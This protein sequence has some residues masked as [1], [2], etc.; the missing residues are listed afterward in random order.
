M[1]EH[2]DTYTKVETIVSQAEDMSCQAKAL[3]MALRS[4]YFVKDGT[5]RPSYEQLMKRSG[6]GSRQT[7]TKHLKILKMR[8]FIDIERISHQ[9]NSYSFPYLHGSKSCTSSKITST[10]T[11]TRLVPKVVLRASTETGTVPRSLPKSSPRAGKETSDFQSFQGTGTET[12]QGPPE[13]IETIM[14]PQASRYKV[15]PAKPILRSRNEYCDAVWHA[16][17]IEN[18]PNACGPNEAYLA[19]KQRIHASR[20]MENYVAQAC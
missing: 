20:F 12:P 16:I 15:T 4:Y 5:C 8:G 1:T 18:D 13:E 6:I 10:E 2:Q 17:Q 9:S 11:D 19:M 7:L 14:S 3:Y